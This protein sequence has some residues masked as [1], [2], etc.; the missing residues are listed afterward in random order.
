MTSN[1]VISPNSG[2]Y[3]SDSGPAYYDDTKKRANS[4]KLITEKRETANQSKQQ[5]GSANTS[6][7]IDLLR[8]SSKNNPQNHAGDRQVK[9]KSNY[10]DRTSLPVKKLSKPEKSPVAVPS[11][12]D[13]QV[14]PRIKLKG[15]NGKKK[16]IQ[17]ENESGI[18]KRPQKLI[19]DN[20]HPRKK[21]NKKHAEMNKFLRNL[22]L[23]R[24]R[25]IRSASDS[26]LN[27]PIVLQIT[28]FQSKSDLNDSFKTHLHKSLS[29]SALYNRCNR[30]KN[31][32]YTINY[33]SILSSGIPV[34]T[35]LSPY[36][37]TSNKKAASHVSQTSINWSLEPNNRKGATTPGVKSFLNV[38]EVLE[39]FK[40]SE[41]TI[42]ELK[43]KLNNNVYVFHAFQDNITK[44]SHD[45][46]ELREKLYEKDIKIIELQAGLR[47]YQSQ[48]EINI[49]SKNLL[50]RL[51][52]RNT[53]SAG[54][55]TDSGS[56]I[57]LD[58]SDTGSIDA[59]QLTDVTTDDE[60]AKNKKKKKSWIGFRSSF[61]SRKKSSG[62]KDDIF[63]AD[64][65]VRADTDPNSPRTATVG[66]SKSTRMDTPPSIITK[67][68][69]NQGSTDKEDILDSST[70]KVTDL[71]LIDELRT[72]IK[73]KDERLNRLQREAVTSNYQS[74]QLTKIVK[75]L[76]TQILQLRLENE[77]LNFQANLYSLK[78]PEAGSDESISFRDDIGVG[79][80]NKLNA[81]VKL[82]QLVVKIYVGSSPA[83]IRL[84][85]KR[86]C[87]L[88][89]PEG[90]LGLSASSIECY[91]INTVK[92]YIEKLI[93]LIGDEENKSIKPF[94]C[95]KKK[96]RDMPMLILIYL[97]SVQ[98]GFTDS[99]V[100]Q[101]LIPKFY[102]QR[103]LALLLDNR[104]V[105]IDGASGSIKTF[106]AFK[107][108]EYLVQRCDKSVEKGIGIFKVTNN[109]EDLISYLKQQ[110]SSGY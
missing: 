73:T 4:R 61:A 94:H 53:G 26:T 31:H 89:D 63:N 76:Q 21:F 29:D 78:T 35:I 92:R 22:N 18:S 33:K 9:D 16:V 105:I 8:H 86:H 90:E 110:Q 69:T 13:S 28:K 88:I 87:S 93:N 42:Y 56:T 6:D 10:I 15:D 52:K 11:N 12:N 24:S 84:L 71:E 75:D 45:I 67:S 1:N 25:L 104:F 7:Y 79:Q 91:E 39:E 83:L 82:N 80:N 37:V 27:S 58:R 50:S 102:I 97:K 77:K 20:S 43:H 62:R 34:K 49:S 2:G 98:L 107:L 36:V 109:A 14:S 40:N 64:I 19:K 5:I 99:I 3:V 59:G 72:V 57:Q 23:V 68:I 41:R 54:S 70:S 47:A 46:K 81:N 95:S 100:Y 74:L 30:K 17:Q 38:E 48:H 55:N 96:D 51:G 66:R 108:A 32:G 65:D 85:I 101:T 106:L 103:Y 44:L 60:S